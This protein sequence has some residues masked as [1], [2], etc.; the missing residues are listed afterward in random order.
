M[1]ALATPLSRFSKRCQKV[2]LAARRINHRGHEGHGEEFVARRARG[3]SQ[4]FQPLG[5]GEQESSLNAEGME[6]NSQVAC[7]NGMLPIMS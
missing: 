5:I 4:E 3:F 6:V 1:C 7:V 2:F